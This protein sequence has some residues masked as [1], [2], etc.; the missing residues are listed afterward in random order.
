MIVG[1]T[2]ADSMT[3]SKTRF[4]V[5]MAGAISGLVSWGIINLIAAMVF[6]DPIQLGVVAKLVVGMVMGGIVTGTAEYA[7]KQGVSLR[8]VALG[9][10][11]GLVGGLLGGLVQIPIDNSLAEVS[12]LMARVIAW[13]V[14][15]AAVATAIAVP[16][17]RRT[18]AR[19]PEPFALG[20]AGGLLGGLVFSF[21]GGVIPDVAPAFAFMLF[22]GVLAAGYPLRDD[23]LTSGA[24]HFVSS[25][26]G[27][28][29]NKFTR[30][31]PVWQIKPNEMLVI[32][33]K[34]GSS[35]QEVRLPDKELNIPDPMVAARHATL[36]T[37][38]GR[39]FLTRHK[40]LRSDAG[41]SSFVLKLRDKTVQFQDEL[42]D[43]D[44]FLVGQTTLVVRISAAV[45][46]P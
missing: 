32:T 8:A 19:I 26:D 40:E 44:D 36:S 33:G 35:R 17:L 28:T 20:L 2:Q 43:G 10:V 23:I 11:L 13:M 37:R 30:T 1:Q 15:G 14:L 16:R 38:D 41:L 4:F 5:V 25:G 29:H 9:L 22:G 6:A 24:I 45:E 3:Q 46:G 21:V 7:L 31:Q 12:P 39:Y 34:Q 27:Y 18:P 42:F